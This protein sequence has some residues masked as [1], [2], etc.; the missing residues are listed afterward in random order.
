MTVLITVVA[1]LNLALGYWLAIYLGDASLPVANSSPE[2]APPSATLKPSPEEAPIDPQKAS[3]K[4]TR[5]EPVEVAVAKPVA[6]E[7]PPKQTAPPEP[8]QTPERAEEEVEVAKPEP[9]EAPAAAVSEEADEEP[10]DPSTDESDESDD[11][12]DLLAGIESFRAQLAQQAPV[13]EGESQSVGD[14]DVPVEAEVDNSAPDDAATDDAPLEDLSSEPFPEAAST[15]E[16][17]E[18]DDD[19]DSPRADPGDD[20][21]AAGIAAFREQ[22]ATIKNSNSPAPVPAAN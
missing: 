6:P 19:D 7:P 10:T 14:A 5:D 4:T 20:E 17:D 12:I 8:V 1:V 3:K 21:V 13:V 2:P 9:L 18:Q 15:D 22:L 16:A 11:E